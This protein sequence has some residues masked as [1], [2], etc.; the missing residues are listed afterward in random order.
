MGRHTNH[1]DF[2]IL[3]GIILVLGALIVWVLLGQ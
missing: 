1:N 3:D 2:D